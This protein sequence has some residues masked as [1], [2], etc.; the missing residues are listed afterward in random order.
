MWICPFLI[1]PI[2]IV[3]S[4]QASESPLNRSSVVP[5]P[6]TVGVVVLFVASSA[7]LPGAALSVVCPPLWPLSSAL[8]NSVQLQPRFSSTSTRTSRIRSCMRSMTPSFSLMASI[9]SWSGCAVPSPPCTGSFP[10]AN[11]LSCSLE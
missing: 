10:S 5:W 6:L 4:L 7:L 2:W 8:S 1:V 3:P 11:G 9:Q